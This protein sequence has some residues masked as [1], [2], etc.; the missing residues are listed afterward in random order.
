MEELIY[1]NEVYQIVG[2]AMEVHDYL[3]HGFLEAV[4]HESLEREFEIR[5]IPYESQKI[6]Q[7][8]YKGKPLSKEYIADFVCHGQIIVE[9][10][11][12]DT[13]NSREHA[14]IINYLKA[15]GYPVGL[16]I[17]FGCQKKLE[18]KR[19]ANT[20]KKPRNGLS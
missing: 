19:F 13:L 5:D 12:L 9:I 2:A 6:L 20:E 10:K 18:W 7:I 16:L 14:Q 8:N 1:K 15:T 4:Y 17:N 3:G 11:A